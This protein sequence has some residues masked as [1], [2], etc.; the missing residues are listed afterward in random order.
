MGK[1]PDPTPAKE[2]SAAATGTN[3]ATAIANTIMGNFN[4]VTPDGTKTT[5]QTGS[6]SFTDPYTGQTY[7]VPTFT[8]NTT[9]SDA[10][11]AIKDQQDAAKLNLSSLANSQSG[12]LQD[13]MSKPWT[14]DQG[15]H[16]KWSLGLYDSLN[17]SKEAQGQQSLASQLANKGIKQGSAAYDRAMQ[18]LGKSQ[19]DSRNQFLL[20]SYGQGFA[21]SQAQRNQ[22]INEI[23]ALMSGSQVSQPQFQ[24]GT[25][26]STIP[27][28]DNASIIA[29]YDQQNAQAAA[30]NNGIW[31]SLLSGLGGLFSLSDE[32]A[33]DDIKEIGQ[34]EDGMGIYSYRYKGDPE[35]R[36]GLMAQEVAKKK[37]KAVAKGPDGLLRVD[38]KKA[39]SKKVA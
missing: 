19:M 28:T 6:Y 4:E 13:Y 11:Q 16:E 38:Y 17:S 37:P 8:T 26:A 20:D 25:G 2:T 18:S 22:P 14:Y 5:N 23:T 7:N 3:V 29:N 35:T 12:F 1:A 24:T 27:T 21:T 15:D 33:K 39:L 34:T 10:Q 9:L 32:R 31:G 36:I 30:Y